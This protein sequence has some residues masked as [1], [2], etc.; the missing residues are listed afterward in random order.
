MQARIQTETDDFGVRYDVNPVSHRADLRIQVSTLTPTEL[1]AG[2]GLIQ[3]ITT[4]NYLEPSNADR[5]RDV[6]QRQQWE[7]EA[8]DNGENDYWFMNPSNAFRYQD[9]PLYLALSSVLTQT[10]W[11]GRLMWMLHKPVGPAEIAKLHRFAATTIP[12]LAGKSGKQ[13]SEILDG[14]NENGLEREL[15]DYW[16]RNIPSFAQDQLL[17]G[18]KQLSLE[19]EEDLRAG[20]ASTIADL[21]TLQRIVINRGAVKIDLTLDPK[22]LEAVKAELSG[23]LE[24]IPDSPNKDEQTES[25][26]N[27]VLDNVGKRYNFQQASFP[28]FI[29]LGDLKNDTANMVFYA[30]FPGYSQ[31]DHQSLIEVLSS[32]LVSGSGPNTVYMKTGEQGLAYASSIASDPSSRLLRYYALRTSDIPTLIELVNCGGA[33]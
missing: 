5:L 26:G 30:D 3:S 16:K 9:D 29:G 32:K 17:T 13:L 23:F 19:V 24:S 12:A 18:L 21:R 27:P 20:P 8:Y 6:V 14:L 10:H 15:L 1:R 2:L 22:N 11:D 31:V 33:R 28:Q 7:D 25:A 4:I